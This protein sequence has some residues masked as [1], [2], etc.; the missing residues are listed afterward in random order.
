VISRVCRRR[1]VAH[2]N[3]HLDAARRKAEA[4][5]DEPGQGPARETPPAPSP[6]PSTP[7]LLG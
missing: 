7:A 4:E 3:A 5:A 1:N 6:R 2:V